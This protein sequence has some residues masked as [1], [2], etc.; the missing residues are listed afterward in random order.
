M[1]GPMPDPAT[2]DGDGDEDVVSSSH[3]RPYRLVTDAEL[4]AASRSGPEQ[5]A[6]AA[7]AAA[8]RPADVKPGF[9]IDGPASPTAQTK[10]DHRSFRAW[11][12]FRTAT[13]HDGANPEIGAST[14]RNQQTVQASGHPARSGLSGPFDVSYGR[15]DGE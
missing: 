14:R 6:A 15:Q 2:L 1:D 5:A 4:L 11:R 10:P 3:G 9:V 8:T 13:A 12:R 7:A